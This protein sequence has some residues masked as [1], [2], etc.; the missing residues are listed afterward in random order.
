MTLNIKELLRYQDEAVVSRAIINKAAGTVTV[1]AFDQGQ[2]LSEHT[3]P[4]DALVIAVDGQVEV[5]IS[6]ETFH[7]REGEMIKMPANKPHALKALTRFKM[8]LIMIRAK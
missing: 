4:Y 1:F 2:E 3:A 6:G 8:I 5:R 7:L